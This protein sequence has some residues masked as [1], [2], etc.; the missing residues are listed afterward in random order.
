METC[1]NPKLKALT[2]HPNPSFRKTEA[3]LSL[4]FARKR[5]FGALTLSANPVPLIAHIPFLLSQD[6]SEAL[7]HLVR[8][9]PIVREAEDR[10]ARLIVTGPDGYV[11]PD[12]YGIDDQVPTWN[13]VSVHLTG[14]LQRL[15]QDALIP[16][17]AAQ[18][19]AYEARLPKTPWT[20]DKTSDD[21]QAR[22]LRMIVPFRLKID[23]LDSTWKLNQ[24]KDD[25]P[26]RAAAAAIESG[27]GSELLELA[28]LMT[29]PPKTD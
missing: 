16:L 2:M 27:F 8:S 20:M 24:N 22:F 21:V 17:L 12:W 13:Y 1:A 7:L 9:N 6:G 3:A 10:P 25:A 29:S 26:R 23:T 11:S 18:S 28:Q 5:A 4:D 15:P 14:T 19:A